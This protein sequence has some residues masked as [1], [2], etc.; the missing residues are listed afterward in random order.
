MASGGF[1]LSLVGLGL[2][3]FGWLGVALERH[4]VLLGVAW[5]WVAWAGLGAGGRGWLVGKS[6]AV[7][8][9]WRL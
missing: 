4:W 2:G 6:K 7:A 5:A 9:K 1:G 3:G 8:L